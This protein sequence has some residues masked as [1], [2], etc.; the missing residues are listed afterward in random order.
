M[1]D[2][3]PVN[4]WA[5]RLAPTAYPAPTGYAWGASPIIYM[6]ETFY[7]GFGLKAFRRTEADARQRFDAWLQQQRC[8]PASITIASLTLESCPWINV[9]IHT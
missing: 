5:F 7:P 3:Q 9:Q 6:A 2:Q 8:D 4:A 1:P